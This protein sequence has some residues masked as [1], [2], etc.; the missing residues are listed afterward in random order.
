MDFIIKLPLSDGITA[1]FVIVD[2]LTKMAPFVPLLNSHFAPKT[3]WVF[4]KKVV[5]LYGVQTS[6]V[7]DRGAHFTLRFWRYLCKTSRHQSDHVIRLPV[8]W[9][10]RTDQTNVRAVP[11]VLL[12]GRTR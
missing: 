11:W 10:N 1:I 4:V 8:Q 7:S 3:A 9:L 12:H 6:I 5:S 2:R